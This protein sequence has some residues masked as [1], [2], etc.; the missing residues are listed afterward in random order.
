MNGF[1]LL[2]KLKLGTKTSLL[3]LFW[4]HPRPTGLMKLTTGKSGSWLLSNLVVR[5]SPFLN[6]IISTVTNNSNNYYWPTV[7]YLRELDII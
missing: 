4:P 2:A 7:L 5:V 1:W 6:A 3:L